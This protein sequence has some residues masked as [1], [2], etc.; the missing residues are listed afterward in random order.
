[1][2]GILAHHADDSVMFDVP[3]PLQCLGLDAYR[4]TWALLFR[5]GTPGP[6][7]FVIQDLHITAGPDVTFAR[8]LLRIGGSLEPLC[9]LT[10]G[11][12]KRAGRWLIVHEH[13]SAPHPRGGRGDGT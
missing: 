12:E 6:D 10:L 1:M 7:L 9:R 8:G 13:H 11:L 5:H 3:E 4:A 2:A